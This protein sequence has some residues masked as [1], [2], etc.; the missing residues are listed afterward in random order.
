MMPNDRNIITKILIHK[1]IKATLEK[2][3]I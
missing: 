2:T 1:K 3:Q